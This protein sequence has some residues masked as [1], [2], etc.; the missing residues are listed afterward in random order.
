MASLDRKKS[1]VT[2][3]PVDLP[4]G[5]KFSKIKTQY[6]EKTKKIYLL[7]LELNEKDRNNYNNYLVKI[8]CETNAMETK[9]VVDEDEKLNSKYK[10]K[11]SLKKDFIAMF[12]SFLVNMDESYTVIYEEQYSISG[13]SYGSTY[14]AGKIMVM[15]YNNKG[16]VT[17]GYIVPKLYNL[18][19]YSQYKSFLYL[20]CGKNK[21]MAI[22]DTERNNEVK[23]DKF[24]IINGVSECDAFIYNLSGDEIVPK[25]EYLF[26]TGDSGHNLTPFKISDYDPATNTLITLKLNKKSPT[27]KA[28]SVVWMQLQ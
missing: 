25:R 13:G 6:I 16:E 10:E 4:E 24:V 26:G 12:S 8:N 20:D 18:D 11:F 15:N 17:S 9:L 3:T 27:N 21:F 19:R 22:N 28:V 2:Y 5:I 14:Y 7:L 23:K 1:N